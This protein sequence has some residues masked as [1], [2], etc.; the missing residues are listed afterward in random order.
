M[1]AIVKDLKYDFV[2]GTT[3]ALPVGDS[4]SFE[5]FLSGSV[6]GG[7]QSFFYPKSITN[8][9]ESSENYF[10]PHA[11]TESQFH[12]LIALLE[13][14]VEKIENNYGLVS[15]E[16]NGVFEERIFS[17]DRLK[18]IN[19]NY[20]GAKIIISI[21]EEKNS[22]ITTIEKSSEEKPLWAS[23]DEEIIRLL[24]QLKKK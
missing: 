7:I 21:T 2:N 4:K 17:L 12:K 23:P 10:L 1:E 19:A 5:T 11:K 18:N 3:L 20:V 9:A 22:I 15:I 16:K 24:H 13:G 14:E 6:T 8:L